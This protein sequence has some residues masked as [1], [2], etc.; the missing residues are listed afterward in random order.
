M[1]SGISN[2]KI[3]A[4]NSVPPWGNHHLGAQRREANC[5]ASRFNASHLEIVAQADNAHHRSVV[6][7]RQQHTRNGAV[8]ACTAQMLGR[9]QPRPCSKPLGGLGGSVAT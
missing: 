4:G 8:G 9:R 1:R 5:A 7:R 3:S 6:A 2:I